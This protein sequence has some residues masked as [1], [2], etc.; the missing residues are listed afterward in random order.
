MENEDSPRRRQ[1]KLRKNE[2]KL[3]K[4]EMKL[5]KSEM[6]LPKNLPFPPWK[7]PYSLGRK[8]DDSEG[9]REFGLEAT[10]LGDEGG[11]LCFEFVE[12]L[13]WVV[14]TALY[15]TQLELPATCHL[16]ALEE[17]VLYRL[18]QLYA[19]WRSA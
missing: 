10:H 18:D 17:R 7:I 2:M 1:T 8:R 3:P 13:P 6:K 9:C 12:K 19:R 5:P 4:S 16:D 11:D 15:L 14:L